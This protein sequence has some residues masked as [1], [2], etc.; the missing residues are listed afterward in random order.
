MLDYACTIYD[1][2]ASNWANKNILLES[3][4]KA[5]AK[6]VLGALRHTSYIKMYDLLGWESLADRRKFMKLTLFFKLIRNK[7]RTVFTALKPQIVRH[8][9][10]VRNA[11]RFYIPIIRKTYYKLSFIPS[12]T[13]L[14][15]NLPNDFKSINS[16]YI[17]KTKVVKLF[18]KT[19]HQGVPCKTRKGEILYNQFRLGTTQLRCDLFRVNVVDSPYCEYCV[20]DIEDY[21]HYFL[22]CP[23]FNDCRLDLLHKLQGIAGFNN[24]SNN[25]KVKLLIFESTDIA[26]DIYKEI[27]LSTE[28]YMLQSQRFRI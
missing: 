9:Y 14:W 19:K 18:R 12:A 10:N 24:L 1:A 23:R 7:C 27:V 2:T 25:N 16:L 5:A 8:H 4:Q 11:N 3:I 13:K 28:T 22:V 6:F 20:N 15:N 21:P 26:P 17:F